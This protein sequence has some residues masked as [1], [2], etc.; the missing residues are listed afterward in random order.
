M[1]GAQLIVTLITSVLM[2]HGCDAEPL[3]LTALLLQPAQLEHHFCCWQLEG[4]QRHLRLQEWP[5]PLRLRRRA[6][7]VTARCCCAPLSPCRPQRWPPAPGWLGEQV[8]SLVSSAAR[9]ALSPGRA[10][11]ASQTPEMSG[12]RKQWRH[13]PGADIRMGE[14][15]SCFSGA[16]LKFKLL[17]ELVQWGASEW[18]SATTKGFSTKW[19]KLSY[20][21][22]Y[23]FWSQLAVVDFRVNQ[24]HKS[25]Q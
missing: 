11:P 18:S 25:I 16:W 3:V 20:Q 14:E 22:F 6:P 13:K 19:E 1:F 5:P 21:H 9:S 23:V 7:S 12:K 15:V 4:P 24:S 8:Y 10:P 17:E 2:I